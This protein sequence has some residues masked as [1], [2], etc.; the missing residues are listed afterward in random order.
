M[1]RQRLPPTGIEAG[2]QYSDV[3]LFLWHIYNETTTKKENIDK[4]FP[5]LMGLTEFQKVHQFYLTRYLVTVGKN[6]S[7]L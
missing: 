3:R 4:K 2:V 5:S 7:G 1:E 6:I